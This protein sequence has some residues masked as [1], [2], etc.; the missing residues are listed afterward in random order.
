MSSYVKFGPLPEKRRRA[1]ALDHAKIAEK[2]RLR[3]G[4][5]AR[6]A[7]YDSPASAYATAWRIKAGSAAYAPKGAFEAESRTDGTK[8]QVWA[9]YV[10]EEARTDGAA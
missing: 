10:G 5:W 1:E 6:I 4:E 7:Q 3:P 8:G 2:L 9:R